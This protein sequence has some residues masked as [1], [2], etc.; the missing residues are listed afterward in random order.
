MLSEETTAVVVETRCDDLMHVL[1]T[2][3][4]GWDAHACIKEKL[5]AKTGD[6]W[7]SQTVVINLAEVRFL[8]SAGIS[9]LL[10]LGRELADQGGK[11]MFCEPPP[12]IRQMFELVG[13]DRLIPVVDDLQQAV[14][15][16]AT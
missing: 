1:V 15:G 3:S 8:D 9:A 12:R 5:T 4:L 14:K 13:M 2:G 6:T 16:S 7:R 11:L 10:L